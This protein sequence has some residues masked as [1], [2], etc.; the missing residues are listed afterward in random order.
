[1]TTPITRQT[2]YKIWI[3]NI[4]SSPYI[5][6]TEEFAPNFIKLNNQEINRVNI[7]A[8]VVETFVNPEQTLASIT[9]DDGSGT[10]HAR[11]FKED[12][13]VLTSIATG[14][15]VMIIGK[16]K[17]YNNERYILP[18]IA[19]T[20]SNAAWGR[21]RRLELIK[22]LG[23]PLAQQQPIPLPP[24]QTQPAV[25]AQ[26]IV[27]PASEFY[28]EVRRAI[29]KSEPGISPE[30]LSANLNVSKEAISS[31]LLDLMKNNEIYQNKPGHYKT[32]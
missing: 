26:T 20:L 32:L 25:Y 2:A 6:S 1:M 23:E 12:I 30:A 7:I 4:L 22:T 27:E 17:E 24:V 15:L 9:L 31:T 29:E 10:I 21:L 14:D 11:A 16:I 3:T 13:K 19:K 18:E 5:K 8:T 28:E